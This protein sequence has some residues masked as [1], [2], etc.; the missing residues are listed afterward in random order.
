MNKDQA[1]G[2]GKQITGEVKE[3]IGKLTGDTSTRVRGH[4][5]EAEGKLQKGLGDAKEVVRH[6][7]RELEA[8][9]QRKL[10]IDR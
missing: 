1:K 4:A 6:H 2:V 10:D 8:D 5:E 3:Q 9:R 7:E